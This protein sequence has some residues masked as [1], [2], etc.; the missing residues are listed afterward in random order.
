MRPI[1]YDLQ[2]ATATYE[3]QS[4]ILKFPQGD[5]LEKHIGPQNH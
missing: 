1:S 2:F 4:D 3:V 5:N